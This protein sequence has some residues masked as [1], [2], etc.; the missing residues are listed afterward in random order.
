MAE[1]EKL[2][3]KTAMAKIPAHRETGSIKDDA[4]YRNMLRFFLRKWEN[5]IWE[6][7]ST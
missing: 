1:M 6:K 5:K 2:G 4:E 3:I 7:I